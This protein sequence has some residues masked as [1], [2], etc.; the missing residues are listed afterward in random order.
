[1]TAREGW[2]ALLVIG[3]LY[4]TWLVLSGK[5]S[6]SS[7]CRRRWWAKGAVAALAAHLLGLW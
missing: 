5:E 2:L 3:G 4:D 7:W 1:M 6:M